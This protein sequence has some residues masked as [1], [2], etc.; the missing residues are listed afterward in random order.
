MDNDKSYNKFSGMPIRNIDGLSGDP[1]LNALTEKIIGC[2]FTV[3]NTLG[4]GFLEKVY[5]NALAH[6]IRKNGLS[7]SQQKEITVYYDNAIVGTYIADLIVDGRVMIE[8]KVVKTLD[9]AHVAQCINYLRATG[10]HICLL[11]NFARTKLDF[12]RIVYN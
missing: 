10:M 11:M 7:V 1:E 4:G 8:L 3:S 6:E 5:E 2:A 9:D 12:R